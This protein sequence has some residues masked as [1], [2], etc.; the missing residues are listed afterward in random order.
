MSPDPARR[1]PEG[2]KHL[3]DS[4]HSFRVLSMLGGP[5]FLFLSIAEFFWYA[6]GKYNALVLVLLLLPGNG[7]VIYA[8][9]RL[10]ERG[11]GGAAKIFGDTVLGAGNLPPDPGFSSEEALIIQGR[12]AEAEEALH[13]RWLR[14]PEL[15]EAG[16]RLAALLVQQDRPEEAEQVYLELR[17][18]ALPPK[19]ANTVANRLI[20]LYQRLRRTDRLKVE[21]ARFSAEHKGTTAGEH[22]ARRLREIKEEEAER[23]TDEG[24]D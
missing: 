4:V 5:L 19:V 23:K 22:A 12:L 11:A 7:L 1:N 13:E 24:G 3:G 9:S 8:L 21:L 10:I 20:D 2:P 16:L 14:H 17:R 15:H 18:R 6:G